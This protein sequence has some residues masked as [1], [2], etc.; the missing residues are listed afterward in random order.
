MKLRIRESIEDVDFSYLDDPFNVIKNYLRK[1][2]SSWDGLRYE[3]KE[4]PFDDGWFAEILF[5]R[6][7]TGGKALFTCEYKDAYSGLIY[8]TYNYHKNRD[9]S[10]DVFYSQKEFVDWLAEEVAE[11]LY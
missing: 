3:F 2:F 4:I 8:A 9:G 10:E 6:P 11:R 7:E 5:T 1:E